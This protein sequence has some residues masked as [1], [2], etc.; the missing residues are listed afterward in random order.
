MR[1]PSVVALLVILAPALAAA[2]T[3][4]METETGGVA[5][6]GRVSGGGEPAWRAAVILEGEGAQA[7]PGEA[8][9]DEAWLSF[10][11]KVQIVS[12]GTRLRLSNHDEATHSVHGWM[13]RATLFQAASAPGG[14][15]QVVRLD[16]PGVVE[17]S[18]DMHEEMRAFLV[19][20]RSRYAALADEEG[21]FVIPSVPA[22]R[23]AVRV[24]W[25]RAGG[26]GAAGEPGRLMESIEVREGL[27]PLSLSLPAAVQR[28]PR[29]PP[30]VVVAPPSVK[31]APSRPSLWQRLAPTTTWPRGNW[32]YLV[33]ALG[34]LVGL[35]VAAANLRFALGTGRSKL[36]AVVVGCAIS[37]CFGALIVVG[38]NGAVATALGF[39]AFL[40][41]ALFAAAEGV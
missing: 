37:F 7:A 25:D 38:L 4:G 19:V 3:T 36:G 22:G 31:R 41:T 29:R 18:C 33:S 8:R 24:F 34:V 17:V 28:P 23:Y 26:E 13:A 6:S 30:T 11:P 27:A 39:G 12:L 35:A 32:V 21:R 40:G 14:L 9:L 5:V 1:L 10:V 16:R 2:A 20:T 15:E